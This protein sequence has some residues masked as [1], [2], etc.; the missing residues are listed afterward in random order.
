MPIPLDGSRGA[1]LHRS[2]RFRWRG[3]SARNCGESNARASPVSPADAA[4]KRLAA[5]SFASLGLTGGSHARA[6]ARADAQR[7]EGR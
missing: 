6:S 3:G 7:P 2:E 1:I 5:A 4:H